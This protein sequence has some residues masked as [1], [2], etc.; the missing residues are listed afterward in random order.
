MEPPWCA[1]ERDED[2]YHDQSDSAYYGTDY[3]GV[4]LGVLCVLLSGSALGVVV[5]LFE[6]LEWEG[7]YCCI[8]VFLYGFFV[9][10]SGLGGG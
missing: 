3:G 8:F 10:E 9:M 5:V 7:S 4:H 6:G 2:K 1:V